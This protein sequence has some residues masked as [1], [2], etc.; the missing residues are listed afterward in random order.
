[1]RPYGW[2]AALA[3]ALLVGPRDATAQADLALVLAVD[4]SASVSDERF[5]LQREGIAQALDSEDLAAVVTS[6]RYKTIEIAVLEWAEEQAIVLPWTAVRRRQDLADLAVQLR[7]AERSWV[8][9]RTDP[10]G[11]IAAASDL[12]DQA[13][14]RS[15]RKVIDLSGDGQQNTGAVATAKARDAALARDITIN[16]LP[17]TSGDEPNVDRWYRDN[18]V[19]GPGAFI[20]VADGFDAFAD[21]FRRKLMIEVA[22]RAPGPT[23]A[24]AP[25]WARRPGK[26][27]KDPGRAPSEGPPGATFVIA[28]GQRPRRRRP[29]ARCR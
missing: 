15:D 16:G 1:V 3:C 8:H 11:A 18:V 17:I 23:L 14:L 22:G 9:T 28:S 10:G 5:H 19:G 6:G 25:R 2:A 4:V 20:V 12:F 24:S 7:C 29:A 27:R 26:M 21:A 13:P